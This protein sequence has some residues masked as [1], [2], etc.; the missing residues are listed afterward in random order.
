MNRRRFLGT[1]AAATAFTLVPSHV[2]SGLGH[3]AP[4][5]KLNVAG[6]GV[7]GQGRGD[8]RGMKDD[9]NIVAL[10]DVDWK[11]ANKTFVDGR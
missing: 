3:L 6:I 5:D 11:Y 4:S 1:T 9:V 7:G 2:I 10:C 8:L